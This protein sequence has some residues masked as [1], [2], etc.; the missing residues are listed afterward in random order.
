MTTDDR[1][2]RDDRIDELLREALQE[3]AD[4]VVPS[5]D[6]LSRIQGRVRSERSRQR[7]MRPALV[8]GGSRV[9]SRPTNIPA[10][11]FLLCW[12]REQS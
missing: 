11:R 3:E 1:D 5:G 8:L 12:R 10:S 4:T 7:W 6:G 9:R 2:D